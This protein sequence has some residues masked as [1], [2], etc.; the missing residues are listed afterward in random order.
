[1]QIDLSSEFGA[2]VA[3]RLHD[4]KIIWLVT[5]RADGT[6]Q[7]NPVWFWWDGESFLIYS[8]G[9]TQKLRHIQQNPRVALHFDS[10]GYGSNIVVFT[11]EA[12]FDS[13]AVPP[14]ECSEYMAKYQ[15]G[16]K[17][18]QMTPETFAQA[19]SVP[20]RITPTGLRGQ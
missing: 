16:I 15:E 13:P 9:N 2:R 20:L 11:G 4:E 10:D 1:M 5:V 7:P 19:F 12:R 8:Q 6:P 3:Q 14:N 18:I 17:S